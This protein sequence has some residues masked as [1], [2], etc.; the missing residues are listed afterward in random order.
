MFT[1]I[2]FT[3]WVSR[4]W[5]SKIRPNKIQK[6][7]EIV[8]KP[9][10]FSSKQSSKRKLSFFS[11]HCISLAMFVSLHLPFRVLDFIDRSYFFVLIPNW[12]RKAQ[13]NS[14]LLRNWWL[15]ISTAE[16]RILKL[17]TVVLK[18]CKKEGK[19]LKYC[20]LSYL[21]HMSLAFWKS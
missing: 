20:L 10:I 4:F 11:Y 6:G 2:Q 8:L 5:S 15:T 3:N 7:L 12:A 21:F 19:K 13:Y 16:P 14:N 18:V 17:L 1:N 9:F